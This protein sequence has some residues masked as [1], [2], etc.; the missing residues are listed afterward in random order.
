MSHFPSRVP[1]WKLGEAGRTIKSGAGRA[2]GRTPLLRALR[3]NVIS[4]L[5]GSNARSLRIPADIW[6]VVETRTGRAVSGC[7]ASSG[8]CPLLGCV[9]S[10]SAMLGAYAC[11]LRAY[12]PPPGSCILMVI[13]QSVP[14]Q[15]GARWWACRWQGHPFMKRWLLRTW[16]LENQREPTLRGLASDWDLGGCGRSPVGTQSASRPAGRC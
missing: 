8:L 14:W 12:C 5:K 11:R 10:A 1:A 4:Q 15:L 13:P 6:H 3:G 2:A 7:Y 9:R 16:I